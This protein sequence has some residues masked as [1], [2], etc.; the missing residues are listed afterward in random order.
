M[1]GIHPVCFE[2]RTNPEI[3]P[4]VR[5][6]GSPPGEDVS[7]ITEEAPVRE[8]LDFIGFTSQPFISCVTLSTLL[9]YPDLHLDEKT[10][11]P[12]LHFQPEN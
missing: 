9:I 1:L 6:Q 11:M 12:G 7:R 2:R 5:G 4:D 3:N 8:G 10:E